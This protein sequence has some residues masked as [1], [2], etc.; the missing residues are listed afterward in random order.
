MI[1][2]IRPALRV[3][4]LGDAGVF[5]LV[6]GNRIFPSVVPQ[7]VRNACLV[8]N[9]VSGLGDHHMQGASG[10][11]VARMQI[12]AWVD[13]LD[14]AED[15]AN[16]VKFRL[17]GYRGPMTAGG[18]HPIVKVQGVFYDTD[19]PPIFDEVRKLH[20]VGRDYMIHYGER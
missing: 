14:A 20:G 15:L 17:D 10:Y 2:D 4:L 19:N 18:S 13:V 9:R 6:G 11:T 1:K 7:G 8:Y 12:A 3:F 5:A 16:L